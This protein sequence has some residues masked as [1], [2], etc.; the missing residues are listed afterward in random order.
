MLRPRPSPRSRRPSLVRSIGVSIVLA[1][2]ASSI[3]VQAALAEAPPTISDPVTDLAGVLSGGEMDDAEAAIEELRA[4][5]GAQ[6]FA[7]FVETTDGTPMPDWATQTA[8]RNSFGRDD[9]LLA[10]AT[11]DRTYRLDV[12]SDFPL[13]DD[14]IDDIG[15]SI[16]PDLAAGRW[17]DAVVGAAEGIGAA[18]AGEPVPSPV[19]SAS[20]VPQP[21]PEPEPSSGGIP[22]FG[23]IGGAILIVAGAIV[24]L[25][26]VG[27]S[28]LNA[29]TA[30][31]RDVQ[32]GD[33]AK[34][35]N[36]L[37]VQ[38]DDLVRDADQEVAFA[39]AQFGDEAKPYR[40]ALA[41]A[42]AELAEAFKLRA[43][44]DDD[45]PE[46][47]ATRQRM[48]QGIVSRCDA[49]RSRLAAEADRFEQFRAIERNAP[50]ILAGMPDQA[51]ALEARL[52]AARAARATLDSYAESDWRSIAG[53]ITEAE[54]RIAFVRRS[55]P[56]GAQA[57]ADGDTAAAGRLARQ[58]QTALAEA[59]ALLD[60]VERLAA[61]LAEARSRTE[62]ELA[63]AEQD[64]RAATAALAAGDAPDDAPTK[65]AELEAT[66]ARIRDALEAERPALL[67]ALDQAQKANALGDEL[68]AGIRGQQEQAARVKAGLETAIAAAQASVTRARDF[69]ATRR[70]GVRAEARTKLVEA[71]R[72]LATALAVGPTDPGAGQREAQTAQT[73]A[74]QAYQ[75]AQSDFDMWDSGGFAGGGRRGGEGELI[76]AVLGGI[77]GGMIGS[78]RG[79][80]GGSPWGNPSRGGS[81]GFGGFGGGFG[82]GGRRGGSGGFGGFGGG[83]GRRGGGGRF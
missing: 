24:L 20:P 62:A 21:E 38:T 14:Q 29:P 15:A 77:L 48:L 34:R 10:V 68:L 53:N 57:L 8:E 23:L 9:L 52:P 6:L 65:I 13:S 37:L 64:I 63:A 32:T 73:L 1:V 70:N 35:A 27:R 11:E 72:H 46:D 78:G 80:F 50:D 83:G 25:R 41:A 51:A 40:E 22:W 58:G 2:A 82:S 54:K 31:E 7:V 47:A 33:L 66:V 43:Q 5:T 26:F 61:S 76:G 39:E 67:A 49:A 4:D 30:E 44:L 79:G 3:A 19:A 45:Q 59:G 81:G 71:E 36:V 42:Q 75:L 60:G 69:I 74:D 56:T 17:G 18:L 16:E 28:R 55:G 12:A